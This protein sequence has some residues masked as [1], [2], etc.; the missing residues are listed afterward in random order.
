MASTT[1]PPATQLRATT[2]STW[3]DAE[4]D[5]IVF[6]AFVAGHPVLSRYPMGMLL[7]VA[8]AACDAWDDGASWEGIALETYRVSPADWDHETVGYF[9]G[10]VINAHCPEH[11]WL[12]D[13]AAET[14][15]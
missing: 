6:E 5:Q 13:Q 4:I 8:D 10:G 2:S 7:D 1:Y 12:L 3:S 15:G 14:W 9:L 11:K